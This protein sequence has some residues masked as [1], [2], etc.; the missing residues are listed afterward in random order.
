MTATDAPA[1]LARTYLASFLSPDRADALTQRAL[2]AAGRDADVVELLSVTH[3][4]LVSEV[5]ITDPVA[6]DVLV[7]D[8]GLSPSQAA[9]VL[10]ADEDQVQEAVAEARAIAD[11]LYRGTAATVGTAPPEPQGAPEPQPG[12]DPAPEPRAAQSVTYVFDTEQ[13]EPYEPTDT[14]EEP[15]SPGRMRTLTLI[16]GALIVT[17]I[18]VALLYQGGAGP[19]PDEGPAPASSISVTSAGTAL[20]GEDGGP[21]Q[22]QETFTPDDAVVFWFEYE[23]LDGDAQVELVL[24]RNGRQLINPEFPLPP[25]RTGTHVTLPRAL[26]EEPGSYTV[27]LLRD[28]ETLT[29]RSFDVASQ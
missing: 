10:A 27:R 25:H 13:V 4:L 29:E 9:R 11:E 21:G 19:Q 22:T 24:S 12:P 16:V 28:G 7:E 23:P 18:A 17:A 8:V 1:E 5:R 26:T 20:P 2:D 15:R 14:F 3:E 6:A